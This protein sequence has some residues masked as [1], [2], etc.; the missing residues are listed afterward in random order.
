MKSRSTHKPEKIQILGD[1]VLVR[2]NIEQIEVEDRI[3]YI[4]DEER[5][6]KDEYIHILISDNTK[7]WD[8]AD[9]LL[10]EVK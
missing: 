6:T 10:K 3:E 1:K 9:Y 8:V 7:L 5:Y 4:C 2:T